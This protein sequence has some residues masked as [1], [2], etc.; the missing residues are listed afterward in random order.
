MKSRVTKFSFLALLCGCFILAATSIAGA[1]TRQYTLIQDEGL[2]QSGPATAGPTLDEMKN[3]G[4]DIVKVTAHWRTA[5]PDAASSTRPAVDLTDPANY[6]WSTLDY[7]VQG[8]QQRGMIP[9]VLIATPAPSWATS[10]DG[11]AKRVGVTNPDPVLFGQFSEALARHYPSVKYWSVMNEPNFGD[12]LWPQVGSKKVSLAA[13]QYRK[14]YAESHAGLVRG[15][16]K[17]DQ[18]MF[19]ELAPR[20]LPPTKGAQSTQPVRFLR[21]FF[22]L[23]DKLKPFKGSAARAHKCTGK[24]KKVQAT[25]FA[26]HP[27]TA[28][29]GPARK[30]T[31]AD[32]APIA[33]LNRLYKVLDKAYSLKRLSKKKIPLWN[34]EFGYQSNPPDIYWTPLKKVAG[35]LNASEFLTYRD[36]RVRSYAQYLLRDEPLGGGSSLQYSGFQSGLFFEDGTVKSGPMASF[37]LPF[38]VNPTRSA[39]RVTFW[40]GVRKITSASQKLQIQ[41]RRPSGSWAKVKT[42]TVKGKRRYFTSSYAARGAK[43]KSYRLVLGEL[44][45]NSTRVTTRVNPRKK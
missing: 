42:V 37:Q 12:W 43:S 32:D 17:H 13:I 29:G 20:A 1:S 3:L 41:V 8:I 21:E 33:A 10:E 24:Y 45:G 6:N 11:S 34:T 19:G 23:D 2:L 36:S 7:A 44:T 40:G 14:L 4:V 15:G 31:Y 27:Y 5:A 28:N 30:P 16:A 9:W 39:N 22:C 38:I 18:I 35:F 26:H 25:G